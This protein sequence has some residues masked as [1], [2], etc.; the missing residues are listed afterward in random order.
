MPVQERP[1]SKERNDVITYL[2]LRCEEKDEEIARLT[3][4]LNKS[5]M[6]L[7]KATAALSP[8]PPAPRVPIDITA[9]LGRADEPGHNPTEK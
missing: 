7:S 9:A 5:Q 1:A 3:S 2:F 8:P 6:A 4:E